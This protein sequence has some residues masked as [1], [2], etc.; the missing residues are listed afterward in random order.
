MILLN[1]NKNSKNKIIIVSPVVKE[2]MYIKWKAPIFNKIYYIPKKY[3]I[4][5]SVK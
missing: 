1:Y 5:S 2:S 4:K 3:L